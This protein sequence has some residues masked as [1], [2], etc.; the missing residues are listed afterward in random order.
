MWR[1]V[2]QDIRRPEFHNDTPPFT[3]SPAVREPQ[4]TG[5]IHHVVNPWP[6]DIPTSS[7][8]PSRQ[9]R[10]AKQI[11]L[12]TGPWGRHRAKTKWVKR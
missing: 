4:V 7:S 10:G 5:G 8:L 1:F 6:M 9:P 12:K 2:P 11:Q 3:P